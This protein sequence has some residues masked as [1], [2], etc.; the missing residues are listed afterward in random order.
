MIKINNIG[1]LTVVLFVFFASGAIAQSR[2]S[3]PWYDESLSFEKRASALVSAMTLE[4]KI[5]QTMDYSTAVP[6][7]AVPE[8]N[9]WNESLHGVARN[10]R[11]TV[12]PQTIGLAA[13]FDEQLI[14]SVARA[15]SDEARAK[16]NA[17]QAIGNRG[18]YAGLTFWTPNVNI[19]RDPR[20]GRGQE[21]YGEDPYLTARMGVNFVKGL[22]GSDPKYLKAAA[23]AKHYLIHSGPEELRHEFDVSVSKKDLYETYLPAFEALV[24]EAQVEG[25]MGAYNRVFGEPASGSPLFLQDILRQ[26]WGFDGYVVSD[27]GAV[28]DFHQFHKV[29]SSPEASAAMALNSGLNLNCG[30]TFRALKKAI[31]QKLTSEAQLD[32]SLKQLYMTRFRLGLFDNGKN[33]PYTSID[34]LVVDSEKHR[35]LAREAAVKSVVML[36]NSKGILPLAKDIR[37]LYVLGPHAT[38]EEV[39]LGNYYGVSSQTATILDGIVSKVSIGTSINYKQGTLAYR[40]NVNPIDWSTGEAKQSEAIIAVMGISGLLEGEEGE[41]LASQ[42]KGD[43]IKSIKLPENQ[44][45]Y[46]KKITDSD[47]PVILVL[48]GGSP[49]ALPEIEPLVDAILFVWYPGEEGGNAVADIIFG[50]R[51][52][53]GKLPITFPY[54]TDQLPPFEDYAM[55]GRT[56]KYM[57]SDPQFPFGFGLSYTTFDYSNLHVKPNKDRLVVQFDLKNKGELPGEEVVQLYISSPLAG[58][59]DAMYALRDFKRVALSPEQ[60]RTITM[61]LDVDD[62]V[63]FDDEGKKILRKGDYKVSIGAAVPTERADELGAAKPISTMVNAEKYFKLKRTRK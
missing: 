30:T 23:C 32:T 8:Y 44:V 61:E 34:P 1:L 51:N 41:S 5:S 26:Q 19:F 2:S 16:F 21:T 46:I 13:S 31:D 25:V 20:W 55:K 11:A 33:N 57:K 12:F 63:Q 10:G 49:I 50:D 9:W 29:T 18:K 53:S 24:S 35:Q 37:S 17:S 54:S 40:E 6:R 47:T 45:E 52:P 60:V 28:K 43:R 59:E 58:T 27:C 39:L 4:E 62:F 3:F 42:E 56:Y 36:K 14:H 48:T 22:Q 15:I 38:S 7:L